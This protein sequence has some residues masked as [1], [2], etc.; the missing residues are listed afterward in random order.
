MYFKSGM[1]EEKSANFVSV[2]LSIIH[3]EAEISAVEYV[4]GYRDAERFVAMCAQ[5]DNYGKQWGCPPFDFDVDAMLEGYSRVRVFATQAYFD[6]PLLERVMTADERKIE[7]KRAL[8]YMWKDLLP[9]LY[10]LEQE[11]EGSRIF[12]GRCRLCGAAA[13]ARVDGK[14]CRHYERL[15]YSLEAVGFDVVKT[16][17]ELLGIELL[18]ST[19]N[20]LPEYVTLITAIFLKD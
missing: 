6:K 18:W 4:R 11:H 13:C 20:H 5:C 10:A 17:R 15:R 2:M 8:D 14:A 9:R 12:T 19:D 16:A 7:T 1:G 3:K